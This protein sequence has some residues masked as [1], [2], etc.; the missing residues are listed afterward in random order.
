LRYIRDEIDANAVVVVVVI[1]LDIVVLLALLVI[2]ASTA[3][4]VIYAALGGLV[5]IFVGE[6]L[7]LRSRY[8]QSHETSRTNACRY[9]LRTP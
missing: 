4:L 9:R 5:L 3:L 8:G 2:K 6:R 7:F 1:I